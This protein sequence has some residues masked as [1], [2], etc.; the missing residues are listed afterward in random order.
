[1]GNCETGSS[2]PL[3]TIRAKDG[4]PDWEQIGRLIAEWRPDCLLVGKPINMDGSASELSRLAEKFGRRLK[5]RFRLPVD[6]EDER[7]S[8]FE[9][10]Q[11]LVARG[12]RGDY[13]SE[14]ADS[15]AAKLIMDTWLARRRPG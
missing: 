11:Q 12:H 13:R 8:S 14:P 15:L 4:I 3:T 2:Q 5:E 7:L 10:K 1:M 9:A 6:F